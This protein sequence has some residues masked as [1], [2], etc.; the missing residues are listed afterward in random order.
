MSGSSPASFCTAHSAQPGP[1]RTAAGCTCTCQPPG[2]D[3][4]SVA[5]A[6]PP[7]KSCTAPAA[8]SAAQVPVV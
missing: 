1:A 4:E 3:R 5:G 2:V 6:C 7:S 8:A